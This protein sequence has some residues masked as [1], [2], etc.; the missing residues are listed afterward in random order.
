MINVEREKV[1]SNYQ[2]LPLNAFNGDFKSKMSLIEEKLLN[3]K[4]DKFFQTI[5]RNKHDFDYFDYGKVFTDVEFENVQFKNGEKSFIQFYIYEHL[6]ADIKKTKNGV[7]FRPKYCLTF[8][9]ALIDNSKG[10]GEFK[11]G[12][13]PIF[14]FIFIDF[15]EFLQTLK[16]IS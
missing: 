4:I 2:F 9:K 8:D 12:S 3:P 13:K 10:Y 14:Y 15:Q 6:L 1:L 16:N 5:N 7:V 11:L